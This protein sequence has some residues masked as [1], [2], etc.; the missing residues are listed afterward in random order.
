[1]LA[2][3]DSVLLG[4]QAERIPAHRMQHVEAAR[5]AVARQNVRG[6]VAF[7]MPDVQ[8]RAARI[9]KHVEDVELRRQLRCGHL[10]GDFVPL[11]ERMSYAEFPRR[12]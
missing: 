6:R 7:R 5:A 1:M 2:G 8:S 11:S 12:G 4:G 3:F 10:A 9:R